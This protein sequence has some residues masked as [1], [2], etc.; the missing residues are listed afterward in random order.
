MTFPQMNA[1]QT[2]SQVEK[3]T[4]S[5]CRNTLLGSLEAVCKGQ[6]S[7][8]ALLSFSWLGKSTEAQTQRKRTWLA[9][10]SAEQAEVTHHYGS[11]SEAFA[12]SLLQQLP[13]RLSPQVCCCFLHADGSRLLRAAACSNDNMQWSLC[14]APTESFCPPLESARFGNELRTM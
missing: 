7:H 1:F 11:A 12:H 14:N 8:F 4:S 6:G 5:C 10:K 3:A 9:T 2:G 13:K